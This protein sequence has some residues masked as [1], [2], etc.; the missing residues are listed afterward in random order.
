MRFGAL[1]IRSKLVL[2]AAALI[3]ASGAIGNA[4]IEA[5]LRAIAAEHVDEDLGVRTDLVA[6]RV[7]AAP[8]ARDAATDAL[9]DALGAA[10]GARVTIALLDGSIAGD[11]ALSLDEI[12]ALGATDDGGR[13]EIRRAL[14]GRRAESE[15]DSPVAPGRVRYMAAPVTDAGAVRGAV[16]LGVAADGAAGDVARLREALAIAAG[17]ALFAAALLALLAARLV[18]QG[19]GS[20]AIAARRLA[21]GDLEA[22]ARPDGEDELAQLG[23]S[24]D[25]LAAGLRSTLRELVEERDLLSGILDNLGEG[26]LLLDREGRIALVNPALREMLLLARDDVGKHLL[27]VVRHAQLADLL[28]AAKRGR[29][30]GEIEVEGLKPRRVLVRAEALDRELG[31]TFVVFYDVTDLRR[32]ETLR[33]DFVANAS[34]E[35]RTPVTSIR[36]ATETLQVVGGGDVAT[37]DK[38]LGIVAR[39]A[40]RLQ[41]LLED[42]LDLSRIESRELELHREEVGLRVAAE[43]AVALL[44]DRAARAKTTV[45]VAIGEDAPPAWVDAR[46]LEQVLE[47]LLDNAIKYCPGARVRVTAE[48]E[49]TSVRLEIADEGPGIEARHLDRLFERFYRVDAGRSRQLGGTGLGLA[50][51]KHLVEAMDGTIEVESEIG[52]GT[53]F[54]I[55]FPVHEGDLTPTPSPISARGD[56]VAPP[57]RSA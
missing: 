5:R 11:S 2:A 6:S 55:R 1:G 45:V 41:R 33:R 34:H 3:A 32:L 57:A 19:V 37:L 50:I 12:A 27:E 9:A 18:S 51:V 8:L 20:L 46:A 54:R 30:Q 16:R 23:R 25:D 15:R 36:S 52:M 26:V 28:E 35:L 48:A 44:S 10:S 14:E 53:T 49:G 56:G 40:E 38:F 29:A 13:P 7:A 43:R 31:G 42:L 24:I 39:N 21:S 47:N 22:R 17:V 4:L